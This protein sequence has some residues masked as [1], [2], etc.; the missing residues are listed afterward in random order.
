M[1]AECL[2]MVH[3]W[4]LLEREFREHLTIWSPLTRNQCLWGPG[5]EWAAMTEERIRCASYAIQYLLSLMWTIIVTKSTPTYMSVYSGNLPII[6][7]FPCGNNYRSIPSK[8]SLRQTPC[9]LL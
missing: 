9:R 8:S 5:I 3:L 7:M 1:Y 2:L 4:R 6:I